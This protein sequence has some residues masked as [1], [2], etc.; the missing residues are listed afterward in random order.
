MVLMMQV[1]HPNIVESR[2]VCFL[3]NHSLPV[4]LME[5]LMSSLHAYLLDPSHH[6]MGLTRK[7]FILCDMASGVLPLQPHT[8]HYSPR[9]DRQE[10]PAGLKPEGKDRRFWK[11]P[12]DRP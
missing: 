6:A 2:G 9:H 4:L 7:A 1:H 12:T 11:Y 3:V 10:Y 5:W 8:G